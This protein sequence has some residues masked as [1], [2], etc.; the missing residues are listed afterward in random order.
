MIDKNRQKT[1][2]AAAERRKLPLRA[3]KKPKTG[4]FYPSKVPASQ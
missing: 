4:D 1:A 2:F 3:S